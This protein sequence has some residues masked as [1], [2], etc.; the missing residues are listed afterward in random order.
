MWAG[1]AALG[2]LQTEQQEAPLDSASRAHCSA[3]WSMALPGDLPPLPE[4]TQNTKQ[5]EKGPPQTANEK[6]TI[7]KQPKANNKNQ[8]EVK[9]RGGDGDKVSPT[10]NEFLGAKAKTNIVG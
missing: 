7:I 9:R 4:N 3:A 10:A 2:A 1:F 8:K 5:K 6:A